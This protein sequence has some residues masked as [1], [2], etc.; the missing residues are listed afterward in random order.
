MVLEQERIPFPNFPWEWAP[1]MLEA[2]AVLTLR[3]AEECL[4]GGFALKDANPHNIMFSGTTPVFLD[5][6]SFVRQ[7]QPERV[8][9]PYAQFVRTFL[10]PL[11]ACRYGGSRLSEIFSLNGDGLDTARMWEILPAWRRLFP[12]MLGFVTIPKMLSRGGGD[13]RQH[14][15]RDRGEAVYVQKA[16]LR[17]LRAALVRSPAVERSEASRYM[18]EDCPYEA[19]AFQTKVTAVSGI[20]QR[21]RPRRVLDAGCNTGYFSFLAADAGAQVVAIDSDVAVIGALFAEVFAKKASILPLVVDLARPSAAMGWENSES[22]SF[23]DRARHAFDCVLMLGFIHHLAVR[24]RVPLDR[25]LSLASE[26]TT[27]LLVLEF[28]SAGD[29]QFV[30]LARGREALH[31]DW[32]ASAFETAAARW[33]EI[34]ERTSVSATRTVYA[35]RKRSA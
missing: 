15:A 35:L 5:L 6:L 2:A 19:L 18:A 11:L 27:N 31:G 3:L 7:A 29:P 14:P 25:I 24:E 23:L 28:V 16:V 13:Y 20:L 17:R 22:A 8:W 12:P 32:T 26:L 33:F 10:Y 30:Q 1:P 21:H 34:A 9:R 4:D